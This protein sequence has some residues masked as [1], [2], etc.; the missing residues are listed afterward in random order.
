MILSRPPNKFEELL[1]AAWDVPGDTGN[2]ETSRSSATET[3]QPVATQE[4]SRAASSILR[5]TKA[6]D[7]AATHDFVES[8]V[9]RLVADPKADPAVVVAELRAAP[10]ENEMRLL[11]LLGTAAVPDQTAAIRLLAELGDPASVPA[12]LRAAGE[13]SLHAVAIGALSRIADAQ[14]IDRLVR[15][16]TSTDL[17]RL[18]LAALLGRD[19]PV[20]LGIYL[21]YVDSKTYGP[22]A[23]AATEL[24]SNPPMERLFS[25]L[26]STS[27]FERL[28]AARVL[29]RIDGP[30]TTER[31][32]AL[33][34]EGQSRQEAC[35]ALL[36]SRGEEAANFVSN[37]RTNPTLATLLQAASVLLSHDSQPR[38]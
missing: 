20:A 24:V 26:H 5:S 19:E 21:N 23:L 37:A 35:V 9:A 34:E 38:S 11:M 8:A 27:E 4:P 36:S 7:P 30:A 10:V 25:T 22:T 29:G 6:V 3:K 18:L 17:Q 28:A 33:F 14:T 16:E 1:I 12:L 31:L 32:I 13:K 15:D 2:R